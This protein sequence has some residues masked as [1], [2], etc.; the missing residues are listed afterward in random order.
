MKQTLRVFFLAAVFAPLALGCDDDAQPGS[1]SP[2]PTDATVSID[3]FLT[4]SEIG[5]VPSAETCDGLDNDCDNTADEDFPVGEECMATLG[6]C[7]APGEWACTEDASGAECVAPEFVIEEERCDEA[8]NDC[9]GLIDE[10][11]NISRDPMNCGACGARC[12]LQN[13]IDNCEDGEC[14]LLR[15]NDGFVDINGEVADGCECG[16]SPDGEVCNQLDDD[17]DGR[18]DEELGLGVVCSVGVGACLRSGEMVCAGDN[19][20]T[21]NAAAGEAVPE[22]CNGSDDDCDGLLDEDFDG[23]DDGAIA[24]PELD[25]DGEC[26]PG[27]DCDLVC[28]RRDCNDDDPT[29]SPTGND[30]CEDGIDQNCDGQDNPCTVHV[31]RVTAMIFAGRDADGCRDFDGDGVADNAFAAVAPIINATIGRDIDAL[32]LNQMGL[33]YGLASSEQNQRF[34]FGL[35]TAR[36]RLGGAPQ[37][38]LSAESLDDEGR[39]LNFFGGATILDG[40][41][42]AGPRDIDFTIPVVGDVVIALPVHRT[43]VVGQLTV[44]AEIDGRTGLQLDE[45]W[46][47][48]VAHEDDFRQRLLPL[49]SPEF[50]GLV[51]QL[52]QPDIDSDGDGELDS[53]GMCVGVTMQP[54]ELVMPPAPLEPPGE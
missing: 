25:C 52:L 43:M 22:E 50:V 17:C 31:G 48:G 42:S 13:A 38:E 29:I 40:H 28:A 20:L 33:V 6:G 41:L 15:C 8:D 9:D 19:T 32:R 30:L 54:E 45:G 27:V 4:D 53:F 10:T 2:Q 51:D 37:F 47:T 11:I 3:G 21:C 5:C 14:V 16:I 34:D 24:C 7:T 1:E 18:V 35:A 12:E 39:P 26:P 23:D 49:L 46:V 36:L 44:P